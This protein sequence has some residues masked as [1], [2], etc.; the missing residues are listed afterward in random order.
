MHASDKAYIAVVSGP[1][2][3]LAAS[4]QLGGGIEL[5]LRY[6][7]DSEQTKRNIDADCLRLAGSPSCWL[8]GQLAESRLLVE[9]K[10]VFCGR[11]HS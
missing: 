8:H 7:P 1:H 10:A 4:F 11:W 2:I 9:T 3:T 5:L 6:L